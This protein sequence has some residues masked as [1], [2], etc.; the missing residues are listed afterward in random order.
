MQYDIDFWSQRFWSVAD[1]V[2][3]SGIILVVVAVARW[4]RG[5]DPEWLRF[6][7]FGNAMA[8]VALAA[9]PYST[10]VIGRWYFDLAHGAIIAVPFIV[11]AMLP[12]TWLRWFALIAPN[13]I[14]AYIAFVFVRL[15]HPEPLAAV[16]LLYPLTF[17][18]A[19]FLVLPAAIVGIV[20]LAK[21]ERQTP[22]LGA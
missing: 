19:G 2:I 4:L 10:V 21:R 11:A 15:G 12:L 1:N 17:V 16:V 18:V 7:V 20:R 6:A 22:Q 9:S 13:A 14:A 8:M 5:R 3:A